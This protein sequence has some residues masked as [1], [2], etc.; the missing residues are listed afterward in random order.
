MQC[1]YIEDKYVKEIDLFL[2]VYRCKSSLLRSINTAV[3]KGEEL[4]SVPQLRNDEQLR[5]HVDYLLEKQLQYDL[6]LNELSADL[7]TLHNEREREEAAIKAK[8]REMGI[9][10]SQLVAKLN[11]EYAKI[12]KAEEESPALDGDFEL[13]RKHQEEQI[14]ARWLE[15]LCSRGY[16]EQRALEL[17]FGPRENLSI[18]E[19]ERIA[20]EVKIKK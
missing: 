11:V 20:K 1:Q 4:L 17:I 14:D 13:Y 8:A 7:K 16:S 6:E 5:A 18:S 15:L 3:K 19:I 9:S 10:V 2:S 12:E